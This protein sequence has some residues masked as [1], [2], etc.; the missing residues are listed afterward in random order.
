MQ[1]I[2]IALDHGRIRSGKTGDL[3]LRI[4]TTKYVSN[5]GVLRRRYEKYSQIIQQLVFIKI[6]YDTKPGAPRVHL[7]FNL[8]SNELRRMIQF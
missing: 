5:H 1:V 8:N 2:Y 3:Y 6:H 7:S 4:I